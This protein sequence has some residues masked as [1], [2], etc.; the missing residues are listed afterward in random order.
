MLIKKR[1]EGL[2]L[3]V[4]HYAVVVVLEVELYFGVSA[5]LV[6]LLRN[7]VSED[8]PLLILDNSLLNGV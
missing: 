6:R 8:F 3:A 7:L 5:E 4:K 2:F 1:V